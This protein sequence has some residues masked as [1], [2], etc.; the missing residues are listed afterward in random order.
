MTIV[1]TRCHRW[2]PGAG[3]GFHTAVVVA[4]VTAM[5]SRTSRSSQ[6]CC[7]GRRDRR[8]SWPSRPLLSQSSWP[9]CRGRR[10]SG[11]RA[12]VVVAV[13]V[14]GPSLLRS[15]RSCCCRDHRGRGHCG[16][17][18]RGHREEV[19][20]LDHNKHPHIFRVNKSG[21][22]LTR[23]SRRAARTTPL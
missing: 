18:C 12:V 14:V 15:S 21:V 20:I 5:L 17:R 11:R 13:V 8:L 2:G 10:C 9:C 3:V 16:H 22:R 19:R 7:R 6:P 23:S 1:M 4:I